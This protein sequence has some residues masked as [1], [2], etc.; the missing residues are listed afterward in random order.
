MAE[1]PKPG[2]AGQLV[3]V[4]GLLVLLAVLIGRVDVGVVQAAFR[5]MSAG[6]A[7]A[8]ATC[9]CMAMAL[10]LGKW[11]LQVEALGLPFDRWVQARNF[12]MGILMGTVTPMRAGELYRLS[13]LDLSE[14][15]MEPLGRRWLAM[16][17]LLLEKGYELLILLGLVLTGGWL[18]LPLT[19]PSALILAA[20]L[21]VW[22][23][24]L[25]FG[26]GEL[27]LPGWAPERL[28][29]LLAPVIEARRRMS[30]GRR[31]TV[32]GLTATAQGL[33]MAGSFQ[34]YQAFGDLDPLLFSFGGPLLTLTTLLPISIS[35]IGVRE[36]AAMEVFGRTGFPADAA[37]VAASL[38]F[39]CANVLPCAALLPLALRSLLKASGAP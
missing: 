12:L 27:T 33:N 32:F 13:A 5:G 22:M 20:L 1:G 26:L 24:G 29:R 8:A 17:A 10:R 25:W 16:A 37:A 3:R 6:R 19:W 14:T 28:L 35:G 9:F 4:A 15:P 38:S 31:L 36:L 30:R 39:F 7:A 21:P 34:I 18:V 23:G 11:N 2:R